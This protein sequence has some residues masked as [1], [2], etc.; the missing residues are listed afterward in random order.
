MLEPNGLPTNPQPLPNC[1]SVCFVMPF[2][3][4]VHH[5]Y[6]LT[7]ISSVILGIDSYQRIAEI[8]QNILLPMQ[9][10]IILRIHFEFCGID[11]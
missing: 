7:V 8:F 3:G 2:D 1:C 5:V 4:V 9:K 10:G 6:R 11:G